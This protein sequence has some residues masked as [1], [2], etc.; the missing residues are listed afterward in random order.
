MHLQVFPKDYK[1]VLEE[2][3]QQRKLLKTEES[4]GNANGLAEPKKEPPAAVSPSK[5]PSQTAN[6]LQV[7]PLF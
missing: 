4:R 2:A 1:R 6:K 3:A 7:G 5:Q